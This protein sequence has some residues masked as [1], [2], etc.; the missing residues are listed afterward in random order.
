V[1]SCR[2]REKTLWIKCSKP[3]IPQ[4]LVIIPSLPMGTK[5]SRK[6]LPSKVSFNDA[7]H[8]LTRTALLVGAL[9]EGRWDLLRDSMEDKLHQSYR[10]TKNKIFTRSIQAAYEAGAL[11]AAISGSGSTLLTFIPK[12]NRK[13][14]KAVEQVFR[15]Q[16]IPIR[17]MP[18]KVDDQG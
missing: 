5:E 10:D 1:I 9:T 4:V 7:V 2:T 18:L 13:V 16:N 3:K 14:G 6:V 17:L 15:K 11:G 12:G 8:N